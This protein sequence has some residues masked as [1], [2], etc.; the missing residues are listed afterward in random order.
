LFVKTISQIKN[1][2][3]EKED[4]KQV[5]MLKSQILEYKQIIEKQTILLEKSLFG[6]EYEEGK[7]EEEYGK[8][9]DKLK[10]SLSSTLLKEEKEIL[11][12]QKEQLAAERKLFT[13]K[14]FILIVRGSH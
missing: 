5:E 12:K 13:G 4:L 11:E 14:H 3:G 6:Q 9:S 1:L 8:I 7:E 2:S 10:Q